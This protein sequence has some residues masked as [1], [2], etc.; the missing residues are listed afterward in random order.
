M[1]K[2]L[3]CRAVILTLGW[4]LLPPAGALGWGKDG[5]Q[6]VAKIAEL[7]LSKD[8]QQALLEI[9]DVSLSDDHIANWAD[10]IR[11]MPAFA[12]I[13]PHNPFWHFVDIPFD[14]REYDREREAKAL[15]ARL[16]EDVG[17]DNNAVEQITRWKKVL[18][19]KTAPALQ[20][21]S[22]LRFLVHFLGDI[23]QPLHCTDR[24][25]RGGN[26]VKVSFMGIHDNHMNLHSV[27]D[28]N[29]VEVAREGQ[30]PLDYA[31][32]LHTAITAAQAA[33]WEAAAEPKAWANEAH[34]L[35]VKVAYPTDAP[36]GGT[37]V[38]HL[39]S[40]YVKVARPVVELQL[41]RAGVR[42]A[43]V[44]NEALAP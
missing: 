41:K 23:H 26:D 5:H 7:R 35:A 10:H 16:K 20:R 13:Y 39:D 15:A 4:L 28:N 25:D 12:K 17:T 6:I 11:A 36:A 22:A 14:A 19:D 29:L 32:K 18:A 3:L 31:H 21:K 9:T 24:N 2:N 43:K 37:G 38:V 1:S 30:D 42:L 8:A 40:A 34:A 27:W 44:L 33:S